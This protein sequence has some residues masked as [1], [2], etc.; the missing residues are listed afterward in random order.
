[1]RSHRCSGDN[2]IR[3]VAEF[4]ELSALWWSIGTMTD[5][6]LIDWTIQEAKHLTTEGREVSD[7]DGTT[8]LDGLSE[9]IG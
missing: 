9:A 3:F 1:M 5:L 4:I 6:D 7:P 8:S 2:R